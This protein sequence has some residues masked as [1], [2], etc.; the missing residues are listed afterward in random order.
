MPK[1]P[2]RV[3]KTSGERSVEPARMGLQEMAELLEVLADDLWSMRRCVLDL[4][5]VL[6]TRGFTDSGP[7]AEDE[8]DIPF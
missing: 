7:I 5:Q 4:Q 1:I 3:V 2:K 6:Y 8:D